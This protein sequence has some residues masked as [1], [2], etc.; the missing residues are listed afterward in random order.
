MSDVSH[1]SRAF[2]SFSVE[3]QLFGIDILLVREI[4]KQLDISTVPQAP[5]YVRGL[6]NLRGQI[7][8]VLD[9]RKRIKNHRCELSGDSHNIIIKN[10]TELT[11]LR[12]QQEFE[13]LST[14]NDNVG[15]LVDSIGEVIN[16]SDD[17][18]EPPPA[19]LGIMDAQFVTGVI[20][21]E[22]QLMAVLNVSKVLEAA[23]SV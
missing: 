8:T 21:L 5:D 12:N 14:T 3:D 18:I 1:L 10:E 9:L 4:N 19:N 20:K 13:S 16:A 6:I 2:V 22:N 11:T 7:V 15:L 23:K 17:H